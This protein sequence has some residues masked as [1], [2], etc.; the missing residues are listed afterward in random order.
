[1]SGP[2]IHYVERKL[3]KDRVDASI[4]GQA[5]ANPHVMNMNMNMYCACSNLVESAPF[6][7]RNNHEVVPTI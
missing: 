6:S 1:M 5:A 3:N 7:L 2:R 4:M